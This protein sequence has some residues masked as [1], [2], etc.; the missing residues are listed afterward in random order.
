MQKLVFE[1]MQWKD[2][3]NIVGDI[4]RWIAMRTDHDLEG[5]EENGWTTQEWRDTPTDGRWLPASLLTKLPADRRENV[6]ARIAQPGCKRIRRLSPMEVW[7]SGSKDLIR[8]RIEHV[9]LLLG[10]ELAETK[11]LDRHGCIKFEGAEYGGGNPQIFPARR[12]TNVLGQEIVI[13]PRESYK[14]F[15]NPFDLSRLVVCDRQL[16]YLGF[17]RRQIG[18]SRA[19]LDAIHKAIG[20]SAH[21]RAVLDA[22]LQAR[23]QADAT[24]R[25]AMLDNNAEVLANANAITV[26]VGETPDQAT[27]QETEAA[28][29]LMEEAT[30]RGE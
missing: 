7:Q 22:P 26:D 6:L 29:K 17:A 10:H 28:L 20:Q 9:P 19:D 11:T 5:W 16:R 1:L 23:H 21:G 15:P 14:V 2:Y 25:Q 18:V 3:E 8:L 12:L 30:N 4:Y 13:D 27:E 24:E